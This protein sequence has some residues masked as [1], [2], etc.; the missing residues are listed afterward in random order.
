MYGYCL[1]LTEL[2]ADH[3][4]S[5]SYKFYEFVYFLVKIC[6]FCILNIHNF[7]LHGES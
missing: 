4:N 5:D 2:I 1:L 6:H 3:W 7:C